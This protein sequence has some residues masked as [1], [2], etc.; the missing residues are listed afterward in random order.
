MALR[1]N[2]LFK[3]TLAPTAC[4]IISPWR[5]PSP[6]PSNRLQP[7]TIESLVLS[8]FFSFSLF[9]LLISFLP[10]TQEVPLF[11]SAFPP[12]F[13]RRIPS[14]LVHN[15]CQGNLGSRP[16]PLSC[17]QE[18]G[19]CLSCPPR[20]LPL[21]TQ[22][23]FGTLVPTILGCHRQVQKGLCSWGRVREGRKP[24]DSTAINPLVISLRVRTD[25]ASLTSS[26]R[27]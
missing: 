5:L 3:W 19:E 4:L 1:I 7:I 12:A 11:P 6:S 18:S 15:A 8:L 13:V 17:R 23:R 2:A 14:F 25:K 20:R 26:T 9:F 10:D 16:R 24:S 21:H 22:G 27:A